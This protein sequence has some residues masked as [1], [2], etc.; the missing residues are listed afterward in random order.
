MAMLYNLT[1]DDSE[2]VE[3]QIAQWKG[4]SFSDLD[5]N[6]IEGVVNKFEFLPKPLAK[7]LNE[8]SRDPSSDYLLI[9][10]GRFYAP[11]NGYKKSDVASE[12]FLLSLAYRLGAPTV[13]PNHKN[14]DVIHDIYP[15]EE[16]RHKQIGGNAE[17]FLFWHTENAHEDPLPSYLSLACIRGDQNAETL[18]AN[19]TQYPFTKNDLDLLGKKEY[20]ISADLAYASRQESTY[21]ILTN[22]EDPCF[23]FDPLYTTTQSKDAENLLDRMAE[24]FNSNAQR[25][26]LEAGDVLLVNNH[27][28]CH[29]RTKFKSNYDGK[30]RW[31]QRVIINEQTRK[32]EP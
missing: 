12:M 2:H 4:K 11:E 32:Y 19:I 1:S 13:D 31:I 29:A 28:C 8:F 18:L 15:R 14:G 17:D 5:A 7:K 24:H 21:A 6:E 27:I 10:G 16:D 20:V 22:I 25:L 3:R 9:K 26:I 30:D 23:R